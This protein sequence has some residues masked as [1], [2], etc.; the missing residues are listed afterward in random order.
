MS[1]THSRWYQEHIKRRK[2][3]NCVEELLSKWF[4]QMSPYMVVGN[5]LNIIT[6]T[7]NDIQSNVGLLWV[8]QLVPHYY[9]T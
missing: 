1:C 6:S 4:D 2:A 7:Y 8:C 3:S 9:T 5:D